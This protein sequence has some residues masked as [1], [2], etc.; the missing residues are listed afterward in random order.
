M[1][2]GAVKR[3]NRVLREQASVVAR[4]WM[5]QVWR[6][7]FGT[8]LRVAW[9]MVRGGPREFRRGSKVVRN[10]GCTRMDTD[11]KGRKTEN[12]KGRAVA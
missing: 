5:E 12:G 8:R 10:H 9:V 1:N 7:S 2:G 6:A 11:G 4:A 3:R